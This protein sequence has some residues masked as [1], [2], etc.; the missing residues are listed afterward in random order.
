MSSPVSTSLS[1][2]LSPTNAQSGDGELE[3]MAGGD[4]VGFDGVGLQL[5]DTI[6]GDA[7]ELFATVGEIFDFGT[8]SARPVKSTF[9][10]V[11]GS[12]T[13]TVNAA[14]TYSIVFAFRANGDRFIPQEVKR[15]GNTVTFDE[16]FWGLVKVGAYTRPYKILK[17]KPLR[18]GTPAQGYTTSYGTVAAFKKGRI[19]I[20]DVDMLESSTGSDEFEIYRVESSVL[21]N[22]EG[23]WEMPDGWPDKPTYP[24][25]ATPPKPKVG[26][27]STRVHEVG[28]ISSTGMFY[29]REFTIVPAKP[30]F[31]DRNYSPKT[32][33]V[34][35]S[36]FG[37]LSDSLKI[38]A[39]EIIA[40][41]GK[42]QYL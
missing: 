19:A 11:S 4:F 40:A 20:L 16:L 29:S 27:V 10:Q 34:Q 32:N 23:E 25:G 28:M 35:G 5:Y 18:Q 3:I 1:F 22:S 42:G 38:K 37:K 12:K 7:P 2:S 13:L 24:N 6:E 14:A 15:V 26:V 8:T 36:G 17:Y 21:L 39:R 30:Y 9:S 33:V 41:R 31:G